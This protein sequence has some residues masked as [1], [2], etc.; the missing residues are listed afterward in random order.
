MASSRAAPLSPGS[1]HVSK[2]DHDRRVGQPGRGHR[3]APE[4]GDELLV[5]GEVR[6]EELHRHPAGEDLVDGLPHRGHA[7]R[8]AMR[9]SS[10]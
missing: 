2:I 3:L 5:G 6:V 7:R 4:P 1:E 8:C 10:R 9:C